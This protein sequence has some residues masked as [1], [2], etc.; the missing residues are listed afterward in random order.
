MQ[1][2]ETGIKPKLL[3]PMQLAMEVN[4]DDKLL[5]PKGKAF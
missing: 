2:I 4:Q 5:T 1:I 3:F